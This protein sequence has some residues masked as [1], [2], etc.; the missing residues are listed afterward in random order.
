MA[1]I[2][3][4]GSFYNSNYTGGAI[5]EAVAQTKA[6]QTD[7]E[8]IKTAINN[9]L[10]KPSDLDTAYKIVTVNN[11]STGTLGYT[12]A[13]T[14]S[15]VMQ[16]DADGRAQVT[17]GISG[18]DIVNFDQLQ[19]AKR[20]KHIFKAYN[21]GKTRQATGYVIN[22][23]PT[24][25]TSEYNPTITFDKM[26][27]QG[28]DINYTIYVEGFAASDGSGVGDYI[29]VVKVIGVTL[30]GDPSSSSAYSIVNSTQ[31]ITL[32]NEFKETVIEV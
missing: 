24:K 5:D 3:P 2:I 28:S 26:D 15:T 32:Y 12:N 25:L 14:P 10:D 16:R 27:Y 1:D 20:Y 17:D 31:E 4:K 13:S 29:A 19:A 7:I 8:G 23:S 11:S 21:E 22:N 9:K 30:T 6:N 18:K